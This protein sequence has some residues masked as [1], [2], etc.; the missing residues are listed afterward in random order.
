MDS[1][2]SPNMGIN[3]LAKMTVGI[4]GMLKG[5]ALWCHVNNNYLV[6]VWWCLRQSA[7]KPHR[8]RRHA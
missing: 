4:Y 1:Y 8:K 2:T 7:G 3:A 6:S 5:L